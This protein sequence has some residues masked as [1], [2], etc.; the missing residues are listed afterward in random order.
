VDGG[1]RVVRDGQRTDCRYLRD[2]LAGARSRHR[3]GPAATAILA[4]AAHRT[5]HGGRADVRAC[6]Q[7]AA[8][9]DRPSTA[10]R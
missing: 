7:P 2:V 5:H 10:T 4:S 9:T 3:A 1:L 6:G 8:T